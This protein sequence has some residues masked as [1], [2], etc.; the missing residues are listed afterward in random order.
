MA[1]STADVIY[2]LSVIVARISGVGGVFIRRGNNEELYISSDGDAE[3]RWSA[4]EYL[5]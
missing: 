2:T 1:M 3:Y 4:D 5:R